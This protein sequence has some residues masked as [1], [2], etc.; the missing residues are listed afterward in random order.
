MNSKNILILTLISITLL[1]CGSNESQKWKNGRII[2]EDGFESGT[3]DS[4]KWDV[5]WW[6]DRQ[7]PDGI[8][9][10]IVTWPVRTGKYAVKMRIN[11]RWNGVK[12][13][14]RTELQGKR[15]DNGEHI[16][17]FDVNGGEYWIGFSSYLPV[18]W[19]FDKKEELIFQLHGN[20]GDRSPPIGLYINGDEWYW[21]LR[22]QPDPKGKYSVAGEKQLWREKYEKGKW[23]DW[24][25]HAKWSYNDDGF[26]EI[27]KD[28]VSIV[29]NYGP[30]CFNDKEGMRGPQTGIYKWP[31]LHGP[32]D[33]TERV[34]Y[35]DDFKVIEGKASYEDV[36]PGIE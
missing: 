27:F 5:T 11:Y 14:N 29:T 2:F 34:V 12:N 13:Y 19:G 25:I 8:K 18:S 22:W 31:W 35:L 30:N 9:P 4:S 3:L 15:N 16:S 6:T 17:F 32:S 33:V 24:V 23:V 28:G 10:E 36:A 20:S 21:Y 26:L 1:S 7:L